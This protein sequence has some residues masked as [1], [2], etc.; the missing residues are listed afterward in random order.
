M[1][2][3]SIEKAACGKIL[4][5][6]KVRSIKLNGPGQRGWPDR[7]FLLGHGKV[8]FIEFKRPG[9]KLT[10]L[11]AYSLAGLESIGYHTAVCDNK[12]DAVSFIGGLVG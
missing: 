10:A 1:D 8:A 4:K 9:G 3:S 7:M 12:N 11:Q 6:L 2:E 5:L